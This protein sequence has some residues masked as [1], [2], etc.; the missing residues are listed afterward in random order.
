[1]AKRLASG[2]HQL[3]RDEVAAHQKRRLFAALGAVMGVKGYT[4]TSVDDLI[5]HAGV[6]RATFYQHFDSKQ[7]C[8]MAGYARM[9]AHVIDATLRTPAAGTPIQ[10]FAIML[11]RYLGFM[12]VDPPT[13]RLY[14]VEV[15]S[16]GPEAM[17]RR[18]EL[19][20]EFVSG[21]AKLIRARSHADRFACTAFVAA[22]SMLVT[23]AL[24][25]GRP[26][27]IL[28][29]KKPILTFAERALGPAALR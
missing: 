19:Q 26:E 10:R 24:T 12:A 29:L 4:A 20:Q 21:V 13:A 1:M 6:S 8:F 5:K 14:L 9:Q 3:T 11:D 15:Y 28:A 23:N 17:R 18:F 2:R 27:D 7:D 22:I 16:A 25:D